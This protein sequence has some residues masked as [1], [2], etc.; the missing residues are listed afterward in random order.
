MNFEAVRRVGTALPGVEESTAYGMPAPKIRGKLL[1]ALPANRSVEPNSLVVCVSSGQRDEL[2]AT[3]PDVYYLTEHYGG[4]DNVLV[5]LSQITT[6]ALQGLLMMAHKYRTSSSR[7]A[8]RWGIS[9]VIKRGK[10]LIDFWGR[11][12]LPSDKRFWSLGR[13]V[14]FSENLVFRYSPL[15]SRKTGF[16]VSCPPGWDSIVIRGLD[17]CLA[18]HACSILPKPRLASQIEWMAHV[19]GQRW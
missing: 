6:E 12:A 17:L 13:S 1:A 7:R 19:T 9:I 10:W 4:Y 15:T 18:T 11:R 2:L 16:P 8:T 5:R 14:G 3:D